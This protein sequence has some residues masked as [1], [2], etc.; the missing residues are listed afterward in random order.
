MSKKKRKKLNI[1]KQTVVGIYEIGYEEVE[2]VFR[3]GQGGEFYVYPE[4]G[5]CARM[6]IGA[7]QERWDELVAV[8]LHEA[9]E[10]VADR[11]K[12][13]YRAFNDI[14]RDTGAFT[15]MFSHS[16]FS[17]ICAKSAEFMARAMPDAS[18]AWKK[19]KKEKK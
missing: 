3:D 8:L 17:D 10:L 15:F 11:L 7:D 19:W 1:L 13:R 12:C 16:D 18:A 6:K 9:F 5:H 2:V 4:K 14:S